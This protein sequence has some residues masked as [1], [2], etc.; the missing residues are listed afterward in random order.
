MWG[1][2]AQDHKGFCVEYDI[3][4]LTSDQVLRKNLYPVIYSPILYDLTSFAEKLVGKNRNDF[5]PSSPLLGVLH[6]FDGWIYEQ[7]WRAVQ[8]T[9]AVVDDYNWAV[10]TPSRVFL[11][12]KM[13]AKNAKEI[14]DLCEPRGIE[15]HRMSMASDR[16]EL[17][18]QRYVP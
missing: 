5:N 2:Y 6:K 12:A 8:Y 13:E 14:F 11:G 3:E 18:S 16:F 9:Q 10:S 15:V 1:H 7:E 17:L 4:A